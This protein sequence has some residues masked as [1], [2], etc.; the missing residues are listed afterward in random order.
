M[1]ISEHPVLVTGASGFIGAELTKQLLARGY[2]V[3][4]TSRDPVLARTYLRDV[5]GA[6]ERLELVEADLLEPESLARSAEGCEY[7]F[8]VASP[9]FLDAGDPQRDLVDPAVSGTR[10]I[11]EACHHSERMRRVVVTSSIA[12]L[13]DE[14]DGSLLTEAS[15]NTTSSPTRSPYYFAKT[16]AE[17]S[18][19]AYV[20]E[21]A[22][23]F[24]LIT[25][26]PAYVLGPSL[27]PR[28]SESAR[29]LVNL[30]NG[31]WPGICSFPWWIVDVRDVAWSH[32]VAMETPEATGRYITG[33]ATVAMREVVGHLRDA[34]WGDKYR[35]P[36]LPLDNRAG[37]FIIKRA[38]RFQPPGTRSWLRTHLGGEFNVDTS[39][40][41]RELG[42]KFR[43]PVRTLL[44]ATEDLERWGHLGKQT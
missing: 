34:G 15:W 43:D 19:W 8:H 37:T 27:V 6:A 26:L 33:A 13:T 42:M 3:R 2:R 23:Q 28:M 22:P 38:V 30:T 17:R 18:A 40:I 41:R 36:W 5:P 7:A 31:T 32:V 14:P 12:A 9:F 39:K 29:N 4:G 11:L 25:I 44:E 24:D 10:A 1:R 21:E 20:D 35:L 16:Q